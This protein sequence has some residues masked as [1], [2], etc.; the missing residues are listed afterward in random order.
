MK[1]RQYPPGLPNLCLV[2]KACQTPE[3]KYFNSCDQRLLKSYDE[4]LVRYPDRVHE[5]SKYVSGQEARAFEE[6]DK[7]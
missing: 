6:A 5:F 4:V 2:S 3:V 7:L 1:P